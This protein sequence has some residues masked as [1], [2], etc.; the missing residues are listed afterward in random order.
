MVVVRLTDEEVIGSTTLH[1]IDT[2][3]EDM[4]QVLLAHCFGPLGLH[5]VQW[6]VDGA[7]LRSRRALERLGLVQEGD[8]A[9]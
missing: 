2:R 4:K 6:T 1:S 8:F 7:N 3:N 9:S 5:R